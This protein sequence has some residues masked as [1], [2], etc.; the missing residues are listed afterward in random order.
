[1]KTDMS[2]WMA[3]LSDDVLI[4]DINLPGAHDAASINKYFR[5]PYACHDH[6]ITDQL[7]SGVRVLDIRIK[8]KVVNGSEY[9]FVTCHGDIGSSVGTNEYQPLGE[10]LDE[11]ADF[12]DANE[13]EALVVI[14][15]IDD[16]SG[17]T[18]RVEEPNMSKAWI[19]ISDFMRKRRRVFRPGNIV[20]TLRRV[21][22][23]IYPMNRIINAART[24]L[25][26]PI[27]WT[28]NTEG[29]YDLSQK[30]RGSSGFKLYVQDKYEDL[31]YLGYEKE[32][33]KLFK[34]VFNKKVDGEVALNFASATHLKGLGVNII[35]GLIGYLG[36]FAGDQRPGKLGWCLFDYTQQRIA[37]MP[38]TSVSCIDL[39]VS[40]NFGYND[41]PEKFQIM[42]RA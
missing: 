23:R 42:L 6:S 12:L 41:F 30:Y 4:S 8:V 15:K 16:W 18:N 17:L 10:V 2:K 32:K 1:M 3:D 26:V 29:S 24:K 39:I 25:G 5:T 28:D 31:P 34:K 33:L 14:L 37:I 19:A 27:H 20:P 9:E 35:P 40:S 22:G 7:K 11:C 38:G 21:R 13:S 36:Q